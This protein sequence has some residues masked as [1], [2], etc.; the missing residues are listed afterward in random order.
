VQLEQL[1]A[2]AP[3][4]IT[5]VLHGGVGALTLSN[6]LL[7]TLRLLTE[8]TGR[9]LVAGWTGREELHLL[10]P[11]ALA[12]ADGGK[13]SGTR[14][15]GRLTAGVL[16]A[17][18]TIAENRSDLIGR[19]TPLRLARELRG[20]W[21]LEG[22]SRW[23]AGQSA[24]ARPAVA[25]RL[26]DGRRPAFPPG[27]RDAPLLGPTVIELLVREA[28]EA[29]AVELAVGGGNRGGEGLERAFGAR[30]VSIEGE[31]RSHLAQLASRER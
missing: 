11:A 26:R 20:A 13:V 30:L 4:R 8:P 17:R 12:A 15:S 22:A 28:G 19:P 18:R 3:P 21:L 1:F 24:H 25:R 16:Y 7:G 31:W 14:E 23:L 9:H 10:S 6:P 29:A 2:R 27:L 5:V